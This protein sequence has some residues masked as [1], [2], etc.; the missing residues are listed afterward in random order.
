MDKHWLSS[1]PDHDADIIIKFPHDACETSVLWFKERLETIPGI[2]LQT[3][4]LSKNIPCSK[5][6]KMLQTKCQSFFVKATYECYLKNLE[7]MH[8]PKELKDEFGGGNKEFVF[9]DMN[10]FENIENFD[11]FLTSQERQSILMFAINRIKA[12]IGELS[13]VRRNQFGLR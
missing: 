2:Y 1:M 3:K 8:I 12:Q 4:S 10:C 13:S 7:Q 5:S 11:A 9:D 6:M